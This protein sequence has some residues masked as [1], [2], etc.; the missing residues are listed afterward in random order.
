MKSSIVFILALFLL[1]VTTVRAVNQQKVDSLLNVLESNPTK[2]SIYVQNLFELASEFYQENLD[3]AFYYCTEAQLISIQTNYQEGIADSYNWI[4]YIFYQNGDL[5]SAIEQFHLGLEANK[6]TTDLLARGNMLNNLGYMYKEVGDIEKALFYLHEALELRK[7]ITQLEGIGTALNNIGLVYKELGEYETA[8]KYLNESLEYRIQTKDTNGMST[9]LNNIAVIYEDQNKMELAKSYLMKAMIQSKLHPNIAHKAMILN[10]LGKLYLEESKLDSAAIFLDSSLTTSRSVSNKLWECATLYNYSKLYLK[11]GNN[12]EAKKMAIQAYNVASTTDF[13]EKIRDC[14]EQLYLIYEEEN[15]TKNAFKFYKEYVLLK[16]SL[17]NIAIQEAAY[18]KEVNYEYNN[19]TQYLEQQQAIEKAVLVK[20]QEKTKLLNKEEQQK[21]NVII[22]F[23]SAIGG[24]LLVFA[25][26]IFSRLKVTSRQKSIIEEQKKQVDHAFSELELKNEEIM[27][28]IAYAKRIQSAIL[29]PDKVLKEHLPN[30]FVL[31]K[32]KDIVAG[33]FYWL[34]TSDNKVLFAAADCTGH[35]VPGAM[36]SV[37]CNNGLN[38]SVR[39][40]HLTDPGKILDKTREIVIQ[41]FAKS[42]DDVK[43]GMDIAL[44]SLEGMQLKYAG[45]H[46]PLWVIRNGKLIEIKADK[47]PIGK[48]DR[49]IDYTT[50][51]V[52]LKTGDSIYI[53]SDGYVDQFGG[54]KGKKFKAKTFKEL[55]LSIQ[56]ESML[57]QRSIINDTFEKWKGELEQLDDVCVIGIRI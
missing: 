26:F 9:T 15:D 25:L 14:A 22:G 17:N 30:S 39:E 34:E 48:F 20:E 50:H 57:V 45:A 18:K 28:S 29:P 42:E 40:H 56:E 52:E 49:P 38:R 24:L 2:D 35:G 1:H 53:F 55:L 16:D 27:D 44:C 36:V 23:I 3:S 54:E 4:G 19:K 12:L 51:L 8:L 11:Q 5:Q 47:Q 31:Y 13:S 6:K 43:D 21:K 10:N 46:N 33:D 37:I 7:Q 41:E 32:P